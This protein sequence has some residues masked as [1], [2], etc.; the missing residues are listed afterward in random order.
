MSWLAGNDACHSHRIM[1][2]VR[3]RDI[4]ASGID[5]IVDLVNGVSGKHI[6]SLPQRVSNVFRGNHGI[7]TILILVFLLPGE[8]ARFAGIGDG[9]GLVHITG[10]IY[11]GISGF[12]TG[13]ETVI[14]CV[15]PIVFSTLGIIIVNSPCR[16]GS[17]IG[18]R[19]VLRHHA[20]DDA[21]LLQAGTFQNRRFVQGVIPDINADGTAEPYGFGS[22]CQAHTCVKTRC[23]FMAGSGCR[24]G[25]SE[26]A[27]A[28]G[29]STVLHGNLL[30]PDTHICCPAGAF[31]DGIPFVFEFR[32]GPVMVNY[33]QH[34]VVGI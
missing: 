5:S 22:P 10:S 17:E 7:G 12:Q 20:V 9:M 23:R 1:V 33:R 11:S 31:G 2:K 6:R 24:L 25:I 32:L 14:I 16:S 13:R 29:R 8:K 28:D 21:R 19:R 30:D 3:I 27:D 18:P 4:A 26:V 34:H 15:E